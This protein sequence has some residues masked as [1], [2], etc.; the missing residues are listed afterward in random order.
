MKQFRVIACRHIRQ[1]RF[2]LLLRGRLWK[3]HPLPPVVVRS[4]SPRHSLEPKTYMSA[5]VS[6]PRKGVL[7]ERPIPNSG[8]TLVELL[9]VIAI[10]G[11]LAAILLPALSRAREAAR[12]ST[13]QNNLKQFGLVFQM[14]ASESSSNKWPTMVSTGNVGLIACDEEDRPVDREGILI[15][16]G[17]DARA[18][19]PEYLSDPAILACP[20]DASARDKFWL[21]EE[22]REVD[23]HIPCSEPDDGLM[24]VDTSYWYM[25]YVFDRANANDP[26]IAPHVDAEAIPTQIFEWFSAVVFQAE[27]TLENFADNDAPVSAP[28]GNGGGDTVFRLRNGVERFLITD[29]NNAGATATSASNVWVMADNFATDITSFNHVPGGCNVLYLDGH[30]EFFKYAP[31]GPAPVNRPI[32][33]FLTPHIAPSAEDDD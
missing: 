30:V 23:I 14:Y 25:G 33:A 19:Y 31:D 10:I 13:C 12:R 15:A 2:A 21:N 22:T 18:I 4:A 16:Y 6:A 32:A 29:I 5:S 1:D 17:P 7:L 28:H 20:S 3:R 9:V 27:I 26:L 24:E 11:I 8:F